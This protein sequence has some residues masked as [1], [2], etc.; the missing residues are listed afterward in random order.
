M[1]IYSLIILIFSFSFALSD[2]KIQEYNPEIKPENFVTE[3]TNPYFSLPIGKKWIYEGTDEGENER[4]QVEVTDREKFVMGIKMTVVRD[5]VWVDGKLEE[6]TF[7]WFAQDKDGNVWYFGEWVENYDDGKIINYSGSWE[8]GIDGGKPGIIMKA[9]PK[10][11][12]SYRQ[13]FLKG[14]AEDMGEVVNINQEV[15]TKF[16]TFKN[17]LQIKDWS[18]LETYIAEYKFFSKEVGNLVLEKKIGEEK[19]FI[20]L[21]EVVNP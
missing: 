19:G 9:N 15:V 12:D 7:D 16:A 18:L 1:K 3:V 10:V 5:R 17:C 11:G 21:V 20:G 14:K 6:D 13:E 2:S 8:A 4:I